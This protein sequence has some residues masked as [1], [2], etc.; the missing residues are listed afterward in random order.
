[1]LFS[2]FFVVIFLDKKVVIVIAA[3]EKGG[4]HKKVILRSKLKNYALVFLLFSVIFSYFPPIFSGE[5]ILFS[6][7]SGRPKCWA[8]C[9]SYSTFICQVIGPSKNSME[10]FFN[11]KF[12]FKSTWNR[13]STTSHHKHPVCQS[14]AGEAEKLTNV[15]RSRY[16]GTNRIIDNWHRCLGVMWRKRKNYFEKLFF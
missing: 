4:Q 1:M 14:P 13:D 12:D 7:F 5:K 2:L 10:L 8:P 15:C 6:Y 9:D 3:G 16:F 11:A